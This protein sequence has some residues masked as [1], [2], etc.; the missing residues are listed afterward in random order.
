[1][2]L[3]GILWLFVVFL[4]QPVEVIE[5]SPVRIV[6]ISRVLFSLLCHPVENNATVHVSFTRKR[7]QA[8]D[9]CKKK[10]KEKS[11]TYS[12]LEVHWVQGV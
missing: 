2:A 7:S 9:C 1:M 8:F 6:I 3:A 4:D 11:V 12:F 5:V 10:K